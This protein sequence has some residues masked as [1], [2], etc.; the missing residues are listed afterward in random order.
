MVFE[1]LIDT[2]LKQQWVRKHAN[3]S[4]YAIKRGIIDLEFKDIRYSNNLD[5]LPIHFKDFIEDTIYNRQSNLY[6]HI[7]FSSSGSKDIPENTQVQKRTQVGLQESNTVT[8]E[9]STEPSEEN[10]EENPDGIETKSQ[11]STSKSSRKRN[12]TSSKNSTK[13]NSIYTSSKRLK[14]LIESIQNSDHL[15][16]DVKSKLNNANEGFESLITDIADL[17]RCIGPKGVNEL[18]QNETEEDGTEAE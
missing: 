10:Q 14:Q 4:N 5:D 1:R 3:K 12:S 18:V 8:T 16:D 15:T 11:T 2:E 9:A 17:R 13:I 6:E 7:S